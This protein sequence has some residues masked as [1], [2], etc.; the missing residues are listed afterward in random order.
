VETFSV[1]THRSR[2]CL[3]LAGEE[4]EALGQKKIGTAHVLLGILREGHGFAVS[5]MKNL[6]ADL[7]Q[8]SLAV[9]TATLREPGETETPGPLTS[10]ALQAVR[11]AA[12][13]RALTGHSYAGTEHLLLGLIGEGDGDAAN[14]LAAF[15]ISRDLVLE[16]ILRLFERPLTANRA[17]MDIAALIAGMVDEIQ[18]EPR[19]E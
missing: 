18:E 15:G 6:G 14:I 2:Y 13:S 8:L 9:R 16:Q 11:L 12:E 5:V 17:P 4:A 19:E 1:L 7:E 10:H 3:S